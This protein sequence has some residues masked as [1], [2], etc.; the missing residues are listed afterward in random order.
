M[1]KN[2]FITGLIWGIIG[3]NFLIWLPIFYHETFLENTRLT[4]FILLILTLFTPVGISIMF[5]FLDLDGLKQTIVS[6]IFSIING[7][8]T[9]LFFFLGT[10]IIYLIITEAVVVSLYFIAFGC[11]FIKI[12]D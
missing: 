6:F 5:A 11:T 1:K 10:E 8:I 9:A 4:S 12:K 7:I 2:Y 3:L